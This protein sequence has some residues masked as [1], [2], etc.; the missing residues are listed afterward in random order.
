MHPHDLL[1]SIL[2][3]SI[4]IC[5]YM[6]AAES[7]PHSS[8]FYLLACSAQKAIGWYQLEVLRLCI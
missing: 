6:T 5:M 4:H 2:F 7:D 8:T 1:V 3:S